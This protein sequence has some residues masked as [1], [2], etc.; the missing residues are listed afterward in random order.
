MKFVI[1]FL[2]IMALVIEIS[3]LIVLSTEYEVK[4]QGILLLYIVAITLST[5][6]SGLYIH[7]DKK[8]F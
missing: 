8:G 4:S 5:I 6:A 1:Q 3:I 7:R 2:N